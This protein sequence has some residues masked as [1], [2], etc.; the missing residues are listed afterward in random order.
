MFPA[1]IPGIDPDE[2]SRCDERG[3]KTDPGT[4]PSQ[5][6]R[7]D[8]G[9]KEQVYHALWKDDVLRALEY[10]EIDVR[11][12]NG[13]VHLDGHIT[14]TTSQSRIKS[15][16][17]AIPG[18]VGVRN[19]LV[20][21]D[22]L[23][24]EV[25]AG[26]AKLE[27]TYGCKFFTGVSHGVVSLSG[28]VGEANV[29]LLAEKYAAGNPNV[30]AV[31]NH[32]R[33]SAAGQG[34]PDQPFLQP[35]IGEIIY[36]LDG[37]SGVVKQV[38]MNPNNRRVVAMTI[39]GKFTDQQYELNSLSDGKARAAEKLVAVP[40]SMVLNLTRVSGFLNMQSNE[41]NRFMEFDPSH[42]FIPK[43]DWKAPYPYCPDDVLFPVERQDLENQISQH[44]AQSP[45]EVGLRDQL[46][47]E[48]LIPTDSPG[49]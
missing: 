24:L 25:A 39:Q 37:T 1:Q 4:S 22:K 33:V 34:L 23:T 7:T 29:K 32:V 14:G 38:I 12:K 21:D 20:L 45:F 2:F 13:I 46:L 36:F 35:A 47:G 6:Q 27:H 9:I 8:S 18:I 15:A 26:L 19:H 42:F 5:I 40:M 3:Q 10:D 44:L 16:M 31:I 41:T 11:V 48:P 28:T 30:R 49:G 43:R 17:R